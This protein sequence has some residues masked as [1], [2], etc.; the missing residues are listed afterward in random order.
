MAKGATI[1]LLPT[2]LNLSLYSGD[3][4]RL[5]LTVKD[6]AAAP[7]PLGPGSITSQIRQTRA[8]ATPVATFDVDLTDEATGI[9]ILSLTGEQTAALANFK[10]VWDVQWQP[11]ETEPR[12]ILQGN[13]TCETDVTR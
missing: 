3:G 1:N 2:V 5:R 8:D 4:V 6:S 13:V 12:T 11:A 7:L 9:V 10:G